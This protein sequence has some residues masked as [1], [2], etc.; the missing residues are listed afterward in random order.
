M[1][2]SR[3]GRRLTQHLSPVRRASRLL[4]RDGDGLGV[5]EHHLVALLDLVESLHGVAHL[6]GLGAPVRPLEFVVVRIGIAGNE[7]E[8]GERSV[9]LVGGQP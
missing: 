4:H 3:F 9:T 7:I 2:A 6:E 8:V 1:A 5:F